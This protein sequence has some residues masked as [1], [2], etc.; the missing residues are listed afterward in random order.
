MGA[1]VAN[2]NC[3]VIMHGHPNNPLS[4]TALLFIVYHGEALSEGRSNK[5]KRIGGT[6]NGRQLEMSTTST[7]CVYEKC[8]LKNVVFPLQNSLSCCRCCWYHFHSYWFTPLSSPMTWARTWSFR[9]PNLIW[10][11]ETFRQWTGETLA[12]FTFHLIHRK[13][14]FWNNMWLQTIFIALLNAVFAV[15][16]F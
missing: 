8:I 4:I 16:L 1:L 2:N 11:T 9:A 3:T 14:Q 5:I 10:T 15:W 12:D 7:F 6:W 13:L